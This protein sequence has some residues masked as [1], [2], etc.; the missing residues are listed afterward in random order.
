MKMLM[1]AVYDRAVGAFMQPMFFRSANEAIRSFQD[2]CSDG[3]TD[4]CKHPEDFHMEALGVFND[5]D[6]TVEPGN[7]KLISAKECV[8]TIVPD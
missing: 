5:A 7:K 4:F 1:C 8:S 6:G 3:K 2:A